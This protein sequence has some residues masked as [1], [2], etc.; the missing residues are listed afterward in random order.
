MRRIHSLTEQLTRHCHDLMKL[1]SHDVQKQAYTVLCDLLIVFSKQ[2]KTRGTVCSIPGMCVIDIEL[3][4]NFFV[5]LELL[6]LLY[7]SGRSG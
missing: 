2:L 7:C 3:Q 6:L 4:L 5:C 1:G